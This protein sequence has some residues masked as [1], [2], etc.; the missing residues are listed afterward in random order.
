MWMGFDILE[1]REALIF[2]GNGYDFNSRELVV[3]VYG[4]VS[5]S[6]GY[7][8]VRIRLRHPVNAERRRKV[9]EPW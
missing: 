7:E 5:V 3:C 6:Y 1:N 4:Y 8:F 2:Y 9:H